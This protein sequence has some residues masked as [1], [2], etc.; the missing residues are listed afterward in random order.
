MDL[1]NF[2]STLCLKMAK[3]DKKNLIRYLVL[4]N[5]VDFYFL[6]YLILHIMSVCVCVCA[7]AARYRQGG[8]HP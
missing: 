7:G 4:V 8:R 5:K 3:Q 2:K 1:Q 6:L